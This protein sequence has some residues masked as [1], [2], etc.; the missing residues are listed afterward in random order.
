MNERNSLGS[1]NVSVSIK[2]STAEA[3]QQ[4]DEQTLNKEQSLMYIE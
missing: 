2:T 3:I 1:K 4:M